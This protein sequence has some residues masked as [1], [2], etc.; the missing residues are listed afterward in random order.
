MA[1]LNKPIS[2][3]NKIILAPMVRVCTLPMRLLALHYGA[4]LVYTEELIDFKL[5]QSTRQI[6]DVL[7]TIDY[8]D[9]TDGTIIFRTCSEEKNRVIL[10]LGTCDP[11]RALK[12]AQL[13]QHDVAGIDINMGCP[14]KFSLDGGMGAALLSNEQKATNILTKLVEGVNIPI[15]CKIRVFDNLQKTIDLVNKL[16]S[17]GISAIA[18]HGRTIHERPQHNN[19]NEMIKSISQSVSIPVIANGGSRE[20][21]KYSDIAQF[22]KET[23]C[24][25]VMIARAAEWN[26]SIFRKEG[27]LPKDDVIKSY[28]K[29]AV[30]YDNSASN[31]KYCIQN[32]IRELQESPLGK[33]FLRAETLEEI[34]KVWDMDEY[35]RVQSKKFQA[36]GLQNRIHFTPASISG[37]KTHNSSCKRKYEDDDVTLMRC[38]FLRGRYLS[39]TDLPKTRLLKWLRENGK[40]D[41]VPRYYTWYENKLFRSVVVVDDKKYSSTYWEK[42]KKRAEQGAALVC[43]CKL[44]VINEGHLKENGSLR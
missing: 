42:N 15:T 20:I 7:G 13:V 18:V 23:H 43:L 11:D 10:Q 6:N 33:I 27:L 28:L 1:E 41:I 9:Q 36:K 12:V 39:D 4:D 5:L 21:E 26:C 44:G 14:K 16:V 19:R 32:I 25:S 30:D 31:T 24:N 22:K 17:T 2:Y 37:A 35:Y 29:Y 3:E 40:S 8:V 34:C 38:V